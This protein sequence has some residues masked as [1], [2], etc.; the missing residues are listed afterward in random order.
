[1][2]YFNFPENRDIFESEGAENSRSLL[3]ILLLA[4]AVIYAL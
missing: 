1:M 3:F 4:A 2:F